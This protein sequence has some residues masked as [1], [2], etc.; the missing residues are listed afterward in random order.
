MGIYM[1]RRNLFF[2]VVF[3]QW[4]LNLCMM[5]FQAAQI[6]LKPGCVL[7]SVSEVPELINAT[8]FPPMIDGVFCSSVCFGKRPWKWLKRGEVVFMNVIVK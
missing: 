6:Q 2:I 7:A 4:P 3:G 8:F 1:G 5:G